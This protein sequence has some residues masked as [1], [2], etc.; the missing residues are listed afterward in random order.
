M[1]GDLCRGPNTRL[2]GYSQ[3]SHQIDCEEDK[4]NLLDL[5]TIF[6]NETDVRKQR[7]MLLPLQLA[8]ANMQEACEEELESA[9]LHIRELPV[10]EEAK[11]FLREQPLLKLSG[12][13]W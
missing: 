5:W 8:M 7:T 1:K 6:A 11:E 3:P 12:D 9:I 10:S 2:S 4:K 13:Q